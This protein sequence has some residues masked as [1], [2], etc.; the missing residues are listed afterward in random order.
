MAV[1]HIFILMA[2]LSRRPLCG[3]DEIDGLRVYVLQQPKR[4]REQR[5]VHCEVV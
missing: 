2:V 1:Q 3:G 4:D 5:N